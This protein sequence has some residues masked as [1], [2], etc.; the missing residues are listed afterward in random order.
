[1]GSLEDLSPDAAVRGI[2]PDGLVTVVTV[3]W[4]GSQALNLTYRTAEGR[5][6]EEFLSRQDESRI[7]VVEQGHPWSFH[8]DG[9]LFR[10][11][12]EAHRIRLAHLFDP[13]GALHTS[14]VDP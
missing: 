2:L 5:V 6:A 10:L 11:A 7:E 4:Y 14:I 1:M 12:S 9:A 8:G 3:Q 13:V